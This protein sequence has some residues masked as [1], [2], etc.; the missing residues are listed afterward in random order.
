M[1]RILLVEDNE[2]N[3]DMLFRRLTRKGFEVSLAADGR[4]AVE[5]ARSETPDL[6][7]MDMSLPVMDGWSATRLLKR[8]PGTSGIP[9]IALTAHAMAEDRREALEAGCDDFDTKPIDWQRLL[10]KI[11]ALLPQEA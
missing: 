6:I 11:A 7:L 1:A 8:E 3:R 10:D 4:E 9:V 2:L 5:K